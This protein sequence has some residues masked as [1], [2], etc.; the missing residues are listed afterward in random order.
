M[1]C[2]VPV[3]TPC[4]HACTSDLPA[5]RHLRRTPRDAAMGDAGYLPV[6]HPKDGCLDHNSSNGAAGSAAG[7][8]RQGGSHQ[9]PGAAAPADVEAQ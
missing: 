1:A 5:C 3:A 6:T 7:E 4:R 8:Q 2:G 9:R